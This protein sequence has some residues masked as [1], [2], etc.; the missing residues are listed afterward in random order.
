[1]DRIGRAVVATGAEGSVYETQ[2]L[3]RDAVVKVRSPKGYRVPELD[4]RIR[5]QRIKSEA[6][7]IREA[8][9]AGIRTP[10]IY[11]VDTVGCAITM[12]KIAG[13][14][15]KEYLDGHPEDTERICGLIGTA[16]ARLHNH[17]LCH[18]D[19]TTSNMILADSGELC[20]IDFSMGSSS[21]GIEDMGV[22]IRLMERAFNSAHPEI[23][24]A[25]GYIMDAYCREKTDSE[26]I[27][28]KVQEIKD[29]GR[30]T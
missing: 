9:S 30:Y 3:G 27:L 20:V 8:R 15:I 24:G 21:V 11:D 23:K 29:R 28:R 16:I 12:E 4:R 26:Q 1:M 2:Y 5:S 17:R 18:G 6:R 25:F 14:T 7:I 22:D 19:L 10:M 13:T